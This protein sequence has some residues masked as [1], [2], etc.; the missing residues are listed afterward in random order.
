[1]ITIVFS[2][3]WHG[4]F[5]HAILKTVTDKLN[6]EN[7]NYQIIDLSNDNF[8]PAMST[9][10]LR[11]YSKGESNYPL[12]NKYLHML[13]QTNEIIFIFPIWWG[14]LPA[15]LK[16][17]F[18]KVLLKGH[19]FNYDS[20]GNIL[21]NLHISR[22]LIIT[23]SQGDTDIYRPYIEGYL[24]PYLLNSVGMNNASWFNCTHTSHGP[25]ENRKNFLQQISDMV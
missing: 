22:T 2:H 13:Q 12:T 20:K 23:T 25:D 3:P 19:S 1:M 8:N 9:E 7:L 17:F 11:L 14:M 6:R 4:S 16:G 24:I 18:D 5:N 21:P 15:N 10:E